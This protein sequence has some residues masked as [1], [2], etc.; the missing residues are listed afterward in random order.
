MLVRYLFLSLVSIVFFTQCKKS[1]EGNGEADQV[2]SLQSVGAL[3]SEVENLPPPVRS[4]KIISFP[5]Q[6][7]FQL[8]FY[9]TE[10]DSILLLRVSRKWEEKADSLIQEFRVSTVLSD[11]EVANINSDIFVDFRLTGNATAD[12]SQVQLFVYQEKEKTFA[13]VSDRMI[14]H[15]LFQDSLIYRGKEVKLLGMDTINH[16]GEDMLTIVKGYGNQ[17]EGTALKLLEVYKAD[18]QKVHLT[19]IYDMDATHKGTYKSIVK[20]ADL[21]F[22]S[23]TDFV[24]IASGK[25]N[26]TEHYNVYTY[27][28]RAGNFKLEKF[29]I[30][31]EGGGFW[32][33]TVVTNLGFDLKDSLIHTS[34]YVYQFGVNTMWS[35]EKNYYSYENGMFAMK[36]HIYDKKYYKHEHKSYKIY[37]RGVRLPEQIDSVIFYDER[38]KQTYYTDQLEYESDRISVINRVLKAYVGTY[39]MASADKKQN[40]KRYLANCKPPRISITA[41]PGEEVLA[42]SYF[43]W[44]AEASQPLTVLKWGLTDGGSRI[45]FDA[46][47]VDQS[48]KRFTLGSIKEVGN[49]TWAKEYRMIGQEGEGYLLEEAILQN[50]EENSEG[51]ADQEKVIG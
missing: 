13:A 3:L 35:I 20:Y 24:V 15:S 33:R 51:C 14:N 12:T 2:D 1:I 48:E 8:D 47:M 17:K 27:D 19:H 50:L 46:R 37:Q 41:S 40:L 36:K 26:S 22:D 32:L 39:T 28:G 10:N 11:F 44:N 6:G 45:F 43:D 9:P 18:S 42:I 7:N 25:D 29:P 4:E 38:H 30:P 5:T 31:R 34:N 49:W 16:S 23:L 21:N